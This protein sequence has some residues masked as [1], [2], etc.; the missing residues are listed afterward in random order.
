[1]ETTKTSQGSRATDRVLEALSSLA[2][3]L[4]RSITE[5]KALDS[6]FQ[7]RLLQAVHDTESSIQNQ[8][9]QHLEAALAETR[10]K[11]EEQFNAKVTELSTAWQAE[12][13][14][15]NVE[16]ERLSKNATQWEIERKRLNGE[17][18]NLAQLQAM[19]QV[20]AEKAIAASKAAA[21]TAGKG[22]GPV[23]SEG[24]QK[25]MERVESLI[26]QISTLMEDASTDLSTV[27]RKNVEKSEL[28]SYL[29]GIRFALNGGGK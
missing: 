14:R 21:L 6:D 25:E 15:L 22:A 20:Q 26:K 9:A 4:D 23:L 11:F 28:E 19:T 16:I 27:I 7:N 10:L 8:A 3:M 2:A 29:K 18:E 5:V 13:S 1:M 12:R 24:L 17:I